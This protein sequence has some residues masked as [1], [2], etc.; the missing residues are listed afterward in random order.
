MPE[1]TE[2]Q[3]GR[4]AYRTGDYATALRIF[5]PLAEQGNARA[6]EALGIM[7]EDG[8][9][10]R[11]NHAESM[12]WYRLAADQGDAL[13]QYSVGLRYER[14]RGVP[15]DFVEAHKWYNL[16]ASR[17]PPG[18]H[19]NMAV[20]QRDLLT[21]EMTREQLAEARKRAREWEPK[22]K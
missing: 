1:R 9:G 8:L 4:F 16:A 18:K 21:G 17:L 5:R 14:G 2:E 13:V 12:K 20:R 11:K 19:R 22:G 3:L 7:Y 6:Q 15:Q 10:V